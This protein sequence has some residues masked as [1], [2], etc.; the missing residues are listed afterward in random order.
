MSKKE[1]L[2]LFW[3]ATAMC[4]VLGG[5]GLF[6]IASA[7]ADDS[8]AASC[9][10]CGTEACDTGDSGCADAKDACA[11]DEACSECADDWCNLGEPLEL[12]GESC[13][14][15]KLG[16]WVQF[17]THTQSNGLFNNHDSMLGLHQFWLY[18]EREAD[19]SNG[20]GWGYRADVVYGLDGPDTQSFGNNAGNWDLAN[21]FQHGIYGWAIPQAYLDFAYE[22]WSVKVGHFYTL[23]GYEVVT[24]PDNF[25]YSHAYTMYN[26]EPFT[27]TGMLATYSGIENVE[28]YSGWTAGWDT[29]FDRFDNGSNFL[30][31]ASVTVTDDITFTYITTMGD[32]GARGEGYSHSVVLDTQVTEKL[33]YVVQ[34]DLVETNNGADHQYGINQ[35]LIYWAN[36]CLGFGGRAE[37]WKNGTAS[38]YEMTLGVNVKP[39]ANVVIR[40][41]VRHDWNTQN[42]F[43]T[44]GVDAIITF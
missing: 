37:W 21:N 4:S 34:S 19:G 35:Y 10:K 17:G 25:F 14:K 44:F 26:S 41:E 32:F 16:G 27:H 12:F 7:S 33:N 28:V 24:A 5:I 29:G 18:L 6:V 40:P 36:D 39:H 3:R 9:G 23:I 8:C 2:R 1:F 31:G 30:G 15:D 11:T 38:Q 42:N 20:L 13:G 22:D 43:T